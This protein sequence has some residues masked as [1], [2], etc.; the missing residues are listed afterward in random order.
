MLR[1]VDLEPATTLAGAT[2]SIT[3]SST[4]NNATTP[5]ASPKMLHQWT[6]GLGSRSSLG[7]ARSTSSSPSNLPH[8]LEDGCRMS[9]KTVVC[10][11]L[12]ESM[13]SLSLGKM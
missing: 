2:A 12:E 1:V 9:R 4:V 13:R 8:A 11:M 7:Q 6:G 10:E 5:P 3:S